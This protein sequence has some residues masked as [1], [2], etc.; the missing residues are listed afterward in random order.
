MSLEKKI[1]NVNCLSCLNHFV[2]YWTSSTNLHK[3]TIPTPSKPQT[4][5]APPI[6]PIVVRANKSFSARACTTDDYCQKP[7][8][9][10]NYSKFADPRFATTP[11]TNRGSETSCLVCISH[12][13]CCFPGVEPSRGPTFDAYLFLWRDGAYYL[14]LASL[15]CWLI[16]LWK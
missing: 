2:K 13:I 12:T 9:F 11:T 3:Y 8:N 1:T 10:P 5:L 15:T 14:S 7:S 6:V 4:V 16:Y